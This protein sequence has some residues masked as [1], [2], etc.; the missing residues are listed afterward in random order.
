MWLNTRRSS[1]RFSHFITI[2]II[3]FFVIIIVCLCESGALPR[4]IVKT[5]IF[6]ANFVLK[7][8]CKIM[9]GL[10]KSRQ[11]LGKSVH[12][13]IHSNVLPNEMGMRSRQQDTSFLPNVRTSGLPGLSTT[14]STSTSESR[15][16]E[17]PFDTIG[18]LNRWKWSSISWII[19]QHHEYSDNNETFFSI[20]V[21]FILTNLVWLYALS[22][23]KRCHHLTGN[24][25]VH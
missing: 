18:K 21:Q 4:S 8:V 23:E 25:N 24:N 15:D 6:L 10:D 14:E 9:S 11:R 12:V 2:I 13:P 5:D 1:H 22:V 3:I 16:A 20:K 17:R 7:I 19:C